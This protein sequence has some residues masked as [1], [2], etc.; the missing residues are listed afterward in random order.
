[1]NVSFIGSHLLSLAF[2]VALF[3][4]LFYGIGYSQKRGNLVTAA[5]RGTL[6]TF[7][8]ISLSVIVLVGSFLT[9]N[10]SLSYVHSYSSRSLPLFYKFAGL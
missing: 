7:I 9:D 1:M 10:F 3:S 5:Q 2:P 6:L 8:L 4:G